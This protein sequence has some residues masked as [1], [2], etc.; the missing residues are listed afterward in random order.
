ML[1]LSRK[2]GQKIV[3]GNEVTVT[4]LA[5]RGGRVKLGFTSPAEVSIHRS[6]VQQAIEDELSREEDL[7]IWDDE[8]LA[9]RVAIVQPS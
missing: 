8:Y 3:I 5:V 9:E 7:E 1:V 2:C 4:V 6:E